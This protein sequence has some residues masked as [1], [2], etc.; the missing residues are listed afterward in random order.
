MGKLGLDRTI[1]CGGRFGETGASF[2][3]NCRI[4]GGQIEFGSGQ[5]NGRLGSRLAAAATARP[6]QWNGKGP[7]RRDWRFG[8]CRA[9]D[10]L[11]LAAAAVAGH[12]EIDGP[13]EFLRN[14]LATAVQNRH[15]VGLWRE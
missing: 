9:D 7:D 6:R 14:V 4:D 2:Q 10:G 5:R 3:R 11:A 15:P 13:Q 8:R 12:S 1:C